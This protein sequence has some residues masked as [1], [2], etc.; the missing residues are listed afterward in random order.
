MYNID[1][2]IKSKIGD[3]C[4]FWVE[5]KN[6][7]FPSDDINLAER[8][9]SAHNAR[10]QAEILKEQ[11]EIDRYSIV[12][13]GMSKNICG[14]RKKNITPKNNKWTKEDHARFMPPEAKAF[15][16]EDK[17]KDTST[18]GEH[19]Q[20]H[21]KIIRDFPWGAFSVKPQKIN[22]RKVKT[23]M[24]KRLYG[25]E[26][27]KHQIEKY[28][29]A[30]N[31]NP[32]AQVRPL[33]LVGP[34]GVGKTVL[35][36]VVAD[37][38]GK[39]LKFISMPALSAGF[40]LLGNGKAW[41]TACLGIIA[42]AILKSG[43]IPVYLLDEIDKASKAGFQFSTPESALLCLF[44]DSREKFTDEFFEIALNLSGVFFILTANDLDLCNEIMLDRC[45]V[46]CVEGYKDPQDRRIILTEYI[47]PKMFKEYNLSYS[48][49][50]LPDEIIDLILEESKDPNG[51]LRI[52]QKQAENVVME[53]IYRKQLNGSRKKNNAFISVEMAEEALNELYRGK[54]KIGFKR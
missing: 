42:E 39:P 16:E 38:M 43:D 13:L 51:G 28:I 54:G 29:A 35:G 33:L 8:F 46:I 6:S 14:D 30:Y 15:L 26:S 32:G 31:E 27:A 10:R 3:S 47:L 40:E 36:K 19:A 24:D 11:G 7:W 34:A 37:V 25:L 50:K 12:C 45:R 9:S 41:G 52:L 49:H 44:D 4:F 23:E 53:L 21:R 18:R 1:Y 17:A 2:V 48:G 22:L 20:Y 5:E